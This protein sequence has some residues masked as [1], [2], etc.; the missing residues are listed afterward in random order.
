MPS[1]CVIRA[2][3]Y[4]LLITQAADVCES[5]A[6]DRLWNIRVPALLGTDDMR[7]L[8][9]GNVV[10]LAELARTYTKALGPAAR[11]ISHIGRGGGENRARGAPCHLYA[12]CFPPCW[13]W[14]T[15]VTF[16]TSWCLRCVAWDTLGVP[17]L[18]KRVLALSI[19]YRSQWFDKQAGTGPSTSEGW[20]R[21]ADARGINVVI[22]HSE[23]HLLMHTF[24]TTILHRSR[25]VSVEIWPERG[26]KQAIVMRFWRRLSADAFGWWR[27]VCHRHF[28]GRVRV[29]ARGFFRSIG[30]A[31]TRRRQLDSR[32]H[33]P[34]T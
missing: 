31:R 16:T 30:L 28:D 2:H 3:T 5:L 11:T 8:Q 7:N 6:R 22:P 33:H 32:R 21:Q 17:G 12:H 19:P 9:L 4:N 18:F 29:Q 20:V 34:T 25:F 24:V 10:G 13:R 27:P 15:W 14:R 23:K 1:R 26:R